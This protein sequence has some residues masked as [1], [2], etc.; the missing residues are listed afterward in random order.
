MQEKLK[1]FELLNGSNF[2]INDRINVYALDIGEDGYYYFNDHKNGYTYTIKK[3]DIQDISFDNEKYTFI[4]NN[5]VEDCFEKI[6]PKELHINHFELCVVR[7]SYADILGYDGE[8]NIVINNGVYEFF[9]RNSD[10]CIIKIN[11][12][13]IEDIIL[14]KTNGIFNIQ[15][16]DPKRYIVQVTLWEHKKVY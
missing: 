9:Y 6:N 11:K 12:N 16:K 3:D 14:D 5:G 7:S 8:Y 1:H 10:N 2:Y 13:E 4:M 15:F